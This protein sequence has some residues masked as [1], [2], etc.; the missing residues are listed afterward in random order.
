MNYIKILHRINVFLSKVPHLPKVR[1]QPKVILQKNSLSNISFKTLCKNLLFVRPNLG[2]PPA[3]G[4]PPTA[5]G[6]I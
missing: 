5:D 4:S 2:A 3:E 1:L 6:T